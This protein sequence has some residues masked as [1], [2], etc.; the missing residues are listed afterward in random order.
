MSI[1]HCPHCGER[2]EPEVKRPDGCICDANEWGDP[3]NL[4][5]VCDKFEG[6]NVGQNCTRCEH[7]YECHAEARSNAIA[8]GREH[9]ERPAGAEG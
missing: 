1:T 4:P 5:P 9:S 8:Q 2:I 6:D 7:D 3:Y